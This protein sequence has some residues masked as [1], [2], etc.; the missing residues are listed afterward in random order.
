MTETIRVLLVDDDA[1]V[2]SGL[3]AIL[4]SAPDI[5][6][7]GEAGDGHGLEALVDEVRPD[8][9]LRDIRMPRLDGL[10][11]TRHLTARPGHPK[12][13]VL[14]TFHLDEYIFGALEAGASGFLL[15][16]TPPR[17]IIEGVR[18]VARGESILSPGDTAKLVERYA[19]RR[20]ETRSA[21][22]RS[23]LA[24]LSERERE[25][26]T[27]VA[28]GASNADIAAGLFV[29]EATVKAHVSH[30]LTKLDL[31]N[32]VQIAIAVLEADLT[33]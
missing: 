24:A 23:R 25:I 11:A 5:E 6:V 16:D 28:S 4:G 19:S 12:I 10:S 33:D 14:T 18:I 20:E 21:A 15:K 8:V 3:S 26:A 22:A 27:L 9:V 2:R 32:R 17:Q 31:E 29:T 7:V 30:I 1:L 13:L